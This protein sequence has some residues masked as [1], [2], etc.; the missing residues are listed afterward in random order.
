MINQKVSVQPLDPKDPAVSLFNDFPLRRSVLLVI[1][2][3]IFIFGSPFVWQLNQAVFNALYSRG[4]L[5][6]WIVP[7]LYTIFSVFVAFVLSQ[8][9]QRYR[10]YQEDRKR[11]AVVFRNYAE[12]ALRSI[13]LLSTRQT[14]YHQVPI[15]ARQRLDFVKGYI[16]TIEVIAHSLETSG[17]LVLLDRGTFR[18]AVDLRMRLGEAQVGAIH[19]LTSAELNCEI[20]KSATP[21]ERLR[22][23]LA[24]SWENLGKVLDAELKFYKIWLDQINDRLFR[25]AGERVAFIPPDDIPQSIRQT[26]STKD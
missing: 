15:N 8:E 7:S 20:E 6:Q 1:I 12:E 18:I 4:I 5:T 13:S 22:S 11:L 17:T 25:L 16:K 9:Y 23:E 3:I 10:D 14:E 21:D 2:T 19:E 26:G 24:A